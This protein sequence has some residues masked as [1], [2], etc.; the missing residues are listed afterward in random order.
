MSET[1]IPTNS[2]R[3]IEKTV[4]TG[5]SGMPKRIKVLQQMFEKTNGRRFWEDVP[6]VTEPG[7][8]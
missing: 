5:I 6:L 2:L 7:G 3:F 4:E 1:R 8:E